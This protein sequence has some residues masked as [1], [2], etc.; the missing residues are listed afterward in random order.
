MKCTL[1]ES[2]SPECLFQ[3]HTCLFNIIYILY[4]KITAIKDFWRLKLPTNF[5]RSLR[6][7]ATSRWD[8]STKSWTKF[9][10]LSTR[11]FGWFFPHNKT[12][13]AGKSNLFENFDV[14][15]FPREIW[16]VNFI[17]HQLRFSANI[18]VCKLLLLCKLNFWNIC[19]IRFT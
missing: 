5:P 6:E 3:I 4:I 2:F 15:V 7:F 13:S 11:F 9:I 10:Y 1:S 16:L 18:Q 17:H 19:L 14:C 8:T 12:I